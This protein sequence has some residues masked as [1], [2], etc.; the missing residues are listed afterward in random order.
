[1]K[2]TDDL[3][4]EISNLEHDIHL[5]ISKFVEE[6]GDCRKI[7]IEVEHPFTIASVNT[8]LSDVKIKVTV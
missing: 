6:V 8:H 7:E 5:V 1:M 4:M 3:R 2:K